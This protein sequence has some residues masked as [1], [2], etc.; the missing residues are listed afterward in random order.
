MM[1]WS[2]VGVLLVLFVGFRF[3]RALGHRIPIIE[4]ILLIA[5]LQWIIGAYIEFRTPFQHSKYYT[6]VDEST[7]M[8]YVVPAY[9]LFLVVVLLISKRAPKINLVFSQLATYSKFGVF[10]LFIGII[11]DLGYSIV[12][13]SLKFLAFLLSSFKYVGIILL[14]F[15][16][17]KWHRYLFY[18]G[19]LFLTSRALM[20]GFFHDLIIW[21]VFFYMFYALK[22][23]PSFKFNVIVIIIGFIMSTLI[24]V[25][26]SDYRTMIWSGYDGSYTTLFIDILNKRLSGGLSESSDQQEELNVRLNQGWIISAIMDYT[27]RNQPFADGDTIKEAVLASAFPRFLYENKKI[28]GGVE[29]FEKFTGFELEENTSMGM[30]LVGEGYANFGIIKGILFM[31]FWGFIIG[32]YW[33]FISKSCYRNPLIIVFLPLIFFQVIKAE[34]ELVVILNHL[35]KATILVFGFLWFTSKVLRINFKND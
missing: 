5:G 7:Y 30:S 8:G 1:I 16:E 17:T 23:K 4:L 19:I 14:F 3:L 11:F 10:I 24:Q 15:S 29:N 35:V 34:T 20:S 28:A 25:V 33:I 2:Y 32:R 22:I 6:Y 9:A 27:P 26:K 12:P 21:S 31:G 18:F 13:D